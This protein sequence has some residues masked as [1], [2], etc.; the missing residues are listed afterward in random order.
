M[1]GTTEANRGGDAKVKLGVGPYPW[2]GLSVALLV[3]LVWSGGAPAIAAAQS[4]PAGAVVEA[5]GSGSAGAHAGILAKV[6]IVRW[7]ADG[8]GSTQIRS[9]FDYIEVEI[10]QLP[11]KAVTLS[12][13]RGDVVIQWRVGAGDVLGLTVRPALPGDVLAFHESGRTFKTAAAAEA[14]EA[15]WAA[16]A[17]YAERANDALTA[18]WLL[19]RAAV[20]LSEVRAWPA[21]DTLYEQSRVRAET[22]G[23]PAVMAQLYRQQGRSLPERRNDWPLATQAYKQALALN[24]KVSEQSMACAG[25]IEAIGLVAL[26]KGDL[27][28][29]EPLFRRALAMRETLAPGSAQFANS[30]SLVSMVLYDRGDAAAAETYRKRAL[31]LFER[32]APNSLLLGSAVHNEGVVAH[33]RGDLAT[34]DKSS[35]TVSRFG[36]RWRRTLHVANS[37][38]VLGWWRGMGAISTRRKRSGRGRSRFAN[39]KYPTAWTWPAPS[40]ILASS[41]VVGGIRARPKS[42]TGARWRSRSAWRPAASTSRER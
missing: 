40:T 23:R 17:Q 6:I 15:H 30:L 27:A 29:A 36:K 24:T 9:V 33:D 18:A 13:R 25:D 3:A 42:S 12:G 11:R 37:L 28:T 32:A 19:N 5:V 31:A 21:A 8:E 41:C 35:G 26:K 7:P 38:N 4:P 2:T 1:R 10:E 16:T 34:A 14:A 20:A 22:F 39:V